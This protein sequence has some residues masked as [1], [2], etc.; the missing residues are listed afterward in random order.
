MEVK[1]IMNEN[2]VWKDIP[3]YEGRYLVSNQGRVFSLLRKKYLKMSIVNGYCQVVL[4]DK[5]GNKIQKQL[6]GALYIRK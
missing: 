2:E 3:H 6:N 4:W 1:I 5:Y